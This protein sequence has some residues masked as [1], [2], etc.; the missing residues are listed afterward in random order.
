MKIYEGEV[1]KDNVKHLG[2]KRECVIV[3]IKDDG[4]IDLYPDDELV[5]EYGVESDDDS[6]SGKETIFPSA[7]HTKID[8]KPF[9]I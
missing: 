7:V 6:N 3:D 2:A 5:E 8:K 1:G 9:G 4:E